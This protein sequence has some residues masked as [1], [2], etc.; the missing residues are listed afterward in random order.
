MKG[1]V[2]EFQLGR[3]ADPKDCIAVAHGQLV[4]TRHDSQDGSDRCFV[5][6][7]SACRNLCALNGGWSD[8]REDDWNPRKGFACVCPSKE[9]Y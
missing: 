8:V 9:W 6:V 7:Q 2:S 1:C 5:R 3:L 4:V